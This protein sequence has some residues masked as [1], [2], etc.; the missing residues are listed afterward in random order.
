MSPRRRRVDVDDRFALVGALPPL[1][2]SIPSVRD[3]L[4]VALPVVVLMALLAAAAYATRRAEREA[5]RAGVGAPVRTPPREIGGVAQA[6]TAS[7]ASDAVRRP[8]S[9][10]ARSMRDDPDRSRSLFSYRLRRTF[11]TRAEG[12]F[13]RSLCAAVEGRYL[14]FAK[15][16]LLDLCGDLDHAPLWAKNRI[17]AKHVDFV[18]CDPSTYRPIAGIE[19][20]GSSHTRH[21]RV[22]RD[23]FVDGFFREL[24]V[25]LVRFR[26]DVMWTPP[27]IL[28]RLSGSSTSAARAFA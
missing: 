15:V 7:V 27:E 26:A 14:V 28:S 18:L 23:E 6:V 19:V 11:F 10:A 12:A 3:W 5:R 1:A 4:L 25:P 17:W 9:P 8:S 20:D 16:R 21:D 24:G 2:L 22:E 13:Y